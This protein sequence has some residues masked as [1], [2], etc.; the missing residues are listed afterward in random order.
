[1]DYPIVHNASKGRFELTIEGKTAVVDYFLNKEV[2]TVIHTYV[3]RG[4][5]GRGIASALAKH[6]LDYA[7]ENEMQVIPACSFIHAYMDRHPAYQT[8][9][10][11][12]HKKG[13]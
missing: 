4:L 11:D 13:G 5:E 9:R 6:V 8:L 7:V 12:N 3:P 1:M 10:V 2:M